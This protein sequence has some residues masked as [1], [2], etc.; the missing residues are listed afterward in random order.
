MNQTTSL[1]Q[2]WPLLPFVDTLLALPVFMR[3]LLASRHTSP[4][5][6][7]SDAPLT[8]LTALILPLSPFPQPQWRHPHL[9]PEALQDPN[10]RGSPGSKHP[11]CGCR[12]YRQNHSVIGSQTQ[13][14][15]KPWDHGIQGST[16]SALPTFRAQLPSLSFTQCSFGLPLPCSFTLCAFASVVPSNEKTLALS[17]AQ[18]FINLTFTKHP[19][20]TRHGQIT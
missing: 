17:L 12:S 18:L 2:S 16:E 11:L 15:P 1:A 8:A 5:P 19:S 10:L 9:W 20:H 3:H 7:H 13:S 4:P 14:G 6:P